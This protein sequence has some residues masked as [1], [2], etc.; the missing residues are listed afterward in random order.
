MNEDKQFSILVVDDEKSNIDVLNHI[1]KDKYRLFIAKCGQSAVK[2]AHENLPDL[3]LLDIIMPGMNGLEVL[4]ALKQSKTTAGIP[5]IFITGQDSKETEIKGL[6]M[7]AVDYIT[8]PFHNVIVEARVSTNMKIVEQMRIIRHM[9]ITDELTGLPNRRY[10]NE[11]LTREWGR[12]IRETL[13]ISMLMIDVDKFKIYNDTY[14]HPQGD[15]LLQAIAGIFKRSLKRPADFVARWGGEEFILLMPNT[16]ADGAADVAER[17]RKNVE[18]M[19]IPCPN[20][21]P[22]GTTVSIGVNSERPETNQPSDAFISK[23]DRALY[24]AKESGRNRVCV[25]HENMGKKDY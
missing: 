11:Q 15:T 9:G 14:G 13:P 6:N 17:I 18:E 8:K 20:G 10:F 12:T 4:A 1:L 19:I 16:G 25:Y 3:I 21:E 23:A 5:V 22:T 24:T 2:V 7:G